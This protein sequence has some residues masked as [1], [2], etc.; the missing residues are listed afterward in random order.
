MI[1]DYRIFLFTESWLV[2]APVL[3]Y[4]CVTLAL[5]LALPLA[6]DRPARDASPP[7]RAAPDRT[8]PHLAA[9]HSAARSDRL[10]VARVMPGFDV[11]R[12]FA[13]GGGGVSP[14]CAAAFSARRSRRR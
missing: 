7:R 3:A 4:A 9:P 11:S 12:A 6:L 1:H 8:S 14:A 13:P 10:L 5:H 2:L